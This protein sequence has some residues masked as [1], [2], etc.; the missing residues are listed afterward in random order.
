MKLKEDKNWKKVIFNDRSILKGDV[1][2]MSKE[3]AESLL[4]LEVKETEY[5]HVYKA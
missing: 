5:K 1:K 2:L 3:Q 4:N